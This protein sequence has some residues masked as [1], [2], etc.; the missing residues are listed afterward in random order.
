MLGRPAIAVLFF[1]AACTSQHDPNAIEVAAE[2]CYACHV[3]DYEG[4]TMPPHV[5]NKPTTCGDCHGTE[6][7][8]P[9]LDGDHPEDA[10]TCL[11]CHDPDLGP[12]TGGMDV[13]CIGCHTGEH[14]RA[15]MDDKHQEESR[16]MWD[17]SRPAFCRD[18]HPR[19]RN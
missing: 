2:D 14:D 18:C 3:A 6:S 15:E 9:A 10:F 11:D 8:T 1:V 4:A 12:T 17:D 13:S 7:W 16:Y 5:G 19:G